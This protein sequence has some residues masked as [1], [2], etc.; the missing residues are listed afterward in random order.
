MRR[1]LAGIHAWDLL[2]GSG[3]LWSKNV[4][5]LAEQV[6]NISLPKFKRRKLET[7]KATIRHTQVRKVG[8]N[9]GQQLRNRKA[10]RVLGLGDI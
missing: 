2:V 7:R 1:S 4:K 6:A 9:R 8:F 10:L 5:I 3:A